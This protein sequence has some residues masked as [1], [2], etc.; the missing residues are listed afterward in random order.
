MKP[1]NKHSGPCTLKTPICFTHWYLFKVSV[2]ATN[3]IANQDLLTMAVPICNLCAHGLIA[4][5]GFRNQLLEALE[6][7]HVRLV[8]LG[9]WRG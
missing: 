8:A 9:D 3:T 5:D 4:N 1:R 7:A 2:P 6:R